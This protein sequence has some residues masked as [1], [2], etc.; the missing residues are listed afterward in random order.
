MVSDETEN[1]IVYIPCK[2]SAQLENIS[3]IF[4]DDVEWLDYSNTFEMLHAISSKTNQQVLCKPIVKLEEDGL[5]V[6]FITETNQFIEISEPQQN[7]SEDGIT[8]YTI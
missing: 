7:L 4:L 5:I 6:G 3:T 8:N 1:N 2:P